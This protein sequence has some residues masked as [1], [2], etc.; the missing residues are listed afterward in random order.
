[1]VKT[2]IA[3]RHMC[4]KEFGV[5]LVYE[6]ALRSKYGILSSVRISNI[7]FIYIS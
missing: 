1:M 7:N 6:K 4:V 5:T 3:L 2:F